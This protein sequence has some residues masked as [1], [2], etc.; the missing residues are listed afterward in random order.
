MI[1]IISILKRESP[2]FTI[3]N[4]RYAF[5]WLCVL[6]P[7]LFETGRV[8]MKGNILKRGGPPPP[9]GGVGSRARR[10]PARRRF[11]R[12]PVRSLPGYCPAAVES[13]G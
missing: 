12:L 5:S 10:V 11:A 3:R 6:I 4:G 13:G 9:P 1:W 8:G 2:H 7:R